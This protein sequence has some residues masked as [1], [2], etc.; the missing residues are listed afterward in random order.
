MAETITDPRIRRVILRYRE[1]IAR[2]T[3]RA[4]LELVSLGVSEPSGYLPRPQ[5]R[6]QRRGTAL[7]R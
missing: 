7:P 4:Y 1:A 6:P 5:T 2:E 3:E